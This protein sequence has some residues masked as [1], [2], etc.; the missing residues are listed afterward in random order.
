[1]AGAWLDDFSVAELSPFAIMVQSSEKE[2]SMRRFIRGMGAFSLLV[3]LG[4]F[5]AACKECNG[6]LCTDD[7]EAPVA[8]LPYYQFFSQIPEEGFC[9]QQVFG[10]EAPMK[11]PLSF[12]FAISTVL[13]G[14]VGL[15]RPRR[16]TMAFQFLYGLLAAYGLFAMAYH[17]T[18][19]NGY[20]RMMDVAISMLQSFIIVML[21]HS[22]YLYRLKTKGSAVRHRGFRQLTNVMTLGF[23]LYPAAVHV[24]GESSANPKVAWYV[25]DFLWILIFALLVLIWRR[26]D[27]WP[28]TAAESR[29]FRLVWR[30]IITCLVAY[31]C[32]A[33]DKFACCAAAPFAAYVGL[34]G[35]WHFFIGLSFYYMITLN[36]FFSAHEYDYDPTLVHIPKAM[37]E[38]GLSFVE[39]QSDKAPSPDEG[40]SPPLDL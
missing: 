40:E 12:V 5:S 25:F 13:L 36:R 16:T 23:T 24:A 10:A 18:L 33:L 21:F 3:A 15:F 26:R 38:Y 37:G 34:H 7:D 19:S 11:E 4:L 9:E 22:L 6:G 35:W 8:G 32:W 39:W 20:Y 28:K 1:M 17:A 30:A 29:V 14:L 27:D 2:V 31:V